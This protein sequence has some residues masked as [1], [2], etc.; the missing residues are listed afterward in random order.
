[1]NLR[2]L[3]NNRFGT[4]SEIYW[5][6]AYLGA[7][8]GAITR[9]TYTMRIIDPILFATQ[10]VPLTYLQAGGQ[11]F[12]F[13][14]FDNDAATQ[15]FNE[16]VASLA[17]AFSHY[18]NDPT[19]GNRMARIQGDSIGFA[20]SLS[21]AVD[22]AYHWTS[23]RGITIVNVAIASI[24]YCRV[25]QL[26]E[27]GATC[28][29]IV[30]HA[31]WLSAFSKRSGLVRLCAS[32]AHAHVGWRHD[33]F[34]CQS[35][36][37]FSDTPAASCTRHCFK[38]LPPTLWLAVISVCALLHVS[39]HAYPELWLAASTK[40]GADPGG[41]GQSEPKLRLRPTQ[42]QTVAAACTNAKTHETKTDCC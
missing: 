2:E 4:Q 9:G 26:K 13:T 31:A 28:S 23:G 8:V 16:V 20:Q 10:Y 38:N 1:M 32:H 19:K 18:T 34:A 35:L 15:L 24:E 14:D 37:C 3:P 5:D 41:W 39:A 22:S 27:C 42:L 7:Q 21:A 30:G 6:D 12:D 36:A 25:W 40:K 33:A 29:A 17:P 11:V